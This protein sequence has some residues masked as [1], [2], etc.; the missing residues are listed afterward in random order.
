[1]ESLLFGVKLLG[2]KRSYNI[3]IELLGR[4][5]IGNILIFITIQIIS[6]NW[7]DI[8]QSCSHQN[9]LYNVIFPFQ[10]SLINPAL[11]FQFHFIK[12]Q[13]NISKETTSWIS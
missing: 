7:T 12:L 11:N 9:Q 10:P 6:S 8:K 13:F 2:W 3:F 4:Y 5:Q 1:M